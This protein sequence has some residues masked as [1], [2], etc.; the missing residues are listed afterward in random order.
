[1]NVVPYKMKVR[2]I[3]IDIERIEN[4]I[5]ITSK[6]LCRLFNLVYTKDF[7]ILNID[8]LSNYIPTSTFEYP[9]GIECCIKGKLNK[10][11]YLDDIL[12]LSK[13]HKQARKDGVIYKSMEIVKPK[14][15]R[16]LIKRCEMVLTVPREHKKEQIDLPLTWE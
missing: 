2:T 10:V 16:E 1:M 13:L 3:K 12:T 5:V 4:R 6:S 9:S 7:N 8:Y 15:I 11:F 14:Q